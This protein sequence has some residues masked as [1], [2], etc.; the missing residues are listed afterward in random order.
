[1][2][3]E[4][5]TEGT[6]PAPPVTATTPVQQAISPTAASAKPAEAVVVTPPSTPKILKDDD[7]V[8]DKEVYQLSGRAF[9]ERVRRFSGRQ[10]RDLFGTD[11]VEAIKASHA[12]AQELENQSEADRRAKLANEERLQED[13]AKAY[14]R[15]EQAEQRAIRVEESRVVDREDQRVRN[16]VLDAGIKPKFAKHAMQDFAEHLSGNFSQE[17]INSFNDAKIKSWFGDYVKENPEYSAKPVDPTP[18]PKVGLSNGLPA[19]ASRPASI[20]S[21][22]IGEKTARPGQ[23]NSMSKDELRKMGYQW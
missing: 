1:M 9:R 23:P 11:D 3:D 22:T 6:T 20:P 2:A 7:E 10:L 5:I 4:L 8:E 14:A 12:R 18:V 21:S 15:A 17:E 19:N 13:L 16:L